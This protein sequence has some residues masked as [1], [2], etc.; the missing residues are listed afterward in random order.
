MPCRTRLNISAKKSAPPNHSSPCWPRSAKPIFFA[1]TKSLGSK[2]SWKRCGCFLGNKH[3]TV[4]P[5]RGEKLEELFAQLCEK[6]SN[7]RR[8]KTEIRARTA[9]CPEDQIS[10]DSNCAHIPGAPG[11]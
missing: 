3:D 5:V 1:R 10:V 11:Q 7:P 6:T 9:A 8:L 2:P 4:N